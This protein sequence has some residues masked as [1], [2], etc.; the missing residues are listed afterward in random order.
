MVNIH[1][2][3]ENDLNKKLRVYM[4]ENNISNKSEAIKQILREKFSISIKQG[5]KNLLK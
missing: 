3:I 4:G 5:F 2:D 1:F